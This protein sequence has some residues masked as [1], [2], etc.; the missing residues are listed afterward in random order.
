MKCIVVIFIILIL[1]GTQSGFSQNSSIKGKFIE[2]E[3]GSALP[4]VSLVFQAHSGKEYETSN[5]LNGVFE[6]RIGDEPG[7]LIIRFLGCYTIKI[8]NIPQ[9]FVPLDLGEIRMVQNYGRPQ[10]YMDGS[11]AEI[12]EE[13][14]EKDKNMREDVL[15]NYRLKVNEKQIVPYFEGN[16]LI[17]DLKQKK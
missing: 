3:T 7:N 1:S 2:Y 13:L 5:E 12:P 16:H 9:E 11:A 4:G 14:I 15:K 6:F 10:F 17:F 8:L